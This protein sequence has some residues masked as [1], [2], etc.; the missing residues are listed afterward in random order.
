VLNINNESDIDQWWPTP[1]LRKGA[2][3]RSRGLRSSFEIEMR[4]LELALSNS[5]GLL[6]MLGLRQ[7]ADAEFVACAVRLVFVL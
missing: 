2:L 1:S 3:P 7:L 5:R 6:L 4:F